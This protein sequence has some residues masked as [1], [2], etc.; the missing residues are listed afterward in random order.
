MRRIDMS[1]EE[2]LELKKQLSEELVG[3]SEFLDEDGVKA[4]ADTFNVSEEEALK[5]LQDC[6]ND[7]RNAMKLLRMKN[8]E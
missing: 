5:V 4:L 1:T 7:L 6:G 2:F 3:K 8:V